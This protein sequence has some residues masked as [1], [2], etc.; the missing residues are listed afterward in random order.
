MKKKKLLSM[1]GLSA[2]SL[3]AYSNI[4][5]GRSTSSFLIEELFRINRFSNKN[6]SVDEQVQTLLEQSVQTNRKPLPLPK[7]FVSSEVYDFYQ[8][9]MQVFCWNDNHDINQK[10]IY[11]IHGGGYVSAPLLFHYKMVDNIAKKTNAKVIFPIYPR[12]P[13][14]IFKDAYP[15]ITKLYETLLTE[16]ISPKQITIMGDSAGGGFSLGLAMWLRDNN[17]PQPK[18]IILLSPWLDLA[19]NN[20]KMNTIIKN[21]PMLSQGQLQVLGEMWADDDIKN[22]YASPIFGKSENLGRISLFTGTNEIFYP[23]I[24]DYHDNL[25]SM[26]INHTLYVA[27]QMNHVFVAYPIPEAK[28]AQ[29]KICEIIQA[30]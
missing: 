6:K 20:S 9:D 24:L 16:V 4:Y 19:T 7:S 1:I 3:Y 29:E 26:G 22:P 17:I 30:P 28:R 23:D 10:I 14:G 12:L 5:K 2:A 21:D 15:K 13:Y 18:D 27:Q 11:Y 8:D 25:N